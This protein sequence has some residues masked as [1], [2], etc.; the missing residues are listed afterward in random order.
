MNKKLNTVLFLL[1]ATLANILITA[2]VFIL[3]F[4]LHV[5]FLMPSLPDSAQVWFIIF[6]FIAA[7]A[8]SFVIYR[9]LLKLLMKKIDVDKYFDSLFSGRRGR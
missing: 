3:L 8:A 4:V 1:G 9:F 5:R 7:I 2:A 6:I